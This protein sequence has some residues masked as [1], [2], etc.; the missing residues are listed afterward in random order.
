VGEATDSHEPCPKNLMD[1][2]QDRTTSLMILG[3]FLAA[4]TGLLGF[5]I[6]RWYP[7][8]CPATEEAKIVASSIVS[9]SGQPDDLALIGLSFDGAHPP[10]DKDFCTDTTSELTPSNTPYA[11]GGKFAIK[12]TKFRWHYRLSG[13]SG[14][15]VW[16]ECSDGKVTS[17]ELPPISGM[18][19]R[20]NGSATAIGEGS[21][22][23][24]GNASSIVVNK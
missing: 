11:V 20:G 21:V 24:S 15:V 2:Q 13:E 9:F 5:R 12:E 6:A 23:N 17:Y 14:K 4:V 10:A 7:A 18:E 16:S 19:A 1:E 8:P 3:L 22:A